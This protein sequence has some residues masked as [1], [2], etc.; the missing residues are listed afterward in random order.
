MLAVLMIPALSSAE[1]MI[2]SVV[3]AKG[4]VTA[5][6]SESGLRTL[7]KGSAVHQGEILETASDSFLVVQLNDG[8]KLTL[9][10][11]SELT[12]EKFNTD[13]GK[14][15]ALFNLLKG[16]LRTISGEIGQ[17]RPD[18]FRVETGI[19]TIGIRGTDFIVRLCED[20]C[21][22]EKLEKGDS[23]GDKAGRGGGNTQKKEILRLGENGTTKDAGSIECRPASEV[24]RGLYVAVLLGGIYVATAKERIELDAI[25]ALVVENREIVCLD[26]VPRFLFRDDYLSRDPDETITLFNILQNIND[27]RPHC[28]IP[29][30]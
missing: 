25:E 20:D 13:E 29:E 21:L 14:E 6:S 1:E 27:E 11:R 17:K 19:A 18:Q 15:E 3:L 12:L 23:Q 7:A 16:G 26:G 5:S 28:A 22:Q 8:T 24:T 4:V 10:P 30:A 9:R 2:G